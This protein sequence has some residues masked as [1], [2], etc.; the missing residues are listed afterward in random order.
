VHSDPT[1][2]P[3]LEAIGITVDFP[4]EGIEVQTRDDPGDDVPEEVVPTEVVAEAKAA[5][6]RR[7]RGE[8][9][10]LTWDSLVD[11]DAPPEDH[12]LRFEHAD[13]QVDVRIFA[14]GGTSNLEG[15]VRPPAPIR[16]ELQ[17]EDGDVTATGDV[18]DGVFALAHI[19]PGVVRLS[20]IG[21][22]HTTLVRTDWFRV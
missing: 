18:D 12:R 6:G 22:I 17:S 5:F 3:L 14:T 21:P 11:E 9:A 7:A 19:P 10:A 4:T 1:G 15:T 13:L 16:V 20:L 8:I 2:Y